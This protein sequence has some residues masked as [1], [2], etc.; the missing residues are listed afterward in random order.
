M[1]HSSK[2]DYCDSKSV[3]IKF[4]RTNQYLT[5]GKSKRFYTG[6]IASKN[7][8]INYKNKT[9]CE[10]NIKLKVYTYTYLQFREDFCVSIIVHFTAV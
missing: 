9:F 10:T 5:K 4:T 6:N 3:H 7:L 2:S 1:G 8:T